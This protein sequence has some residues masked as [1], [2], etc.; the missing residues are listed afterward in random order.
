M[1]AGGCFFSGYLV[2]ST[3]KTYRHDIAEILLKVALNTLIH[4][5]GSRMIIILIYIIFWYIYIMEFAK[6]VFFIIIIFFFY[7][8]WQNMQIRMILTKKSFENLLLCK[9]WAKIN[10]ILQEW[11]FGSGHFWKSYLTA[12]TFITKSRNFLKVSWNLNLFYA[13]ELFNIIWDFPWNF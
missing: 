6:T 9:K 10:K 4:I 3:N 13:N 12:L 2:S 5:L 8:F 7:K 11:S 1:A